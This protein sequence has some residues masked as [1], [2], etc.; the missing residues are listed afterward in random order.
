MPVFPP[1]F[2]RTLRP[3]RSKWFPLPIAIVFSSPILAFGGGMDL[4]RIGAILLATF[5]AVYFVWKRR[6]QLPSGDIEYYADRLVLTVQ[7]KRLEILF[8]E[9]EE[10]KYSFMQWQD[11]VVEVNMRSGNSHA[12]PASIARLDYFFDRLAEA[13][14]DLAKNPNF[15]RFRDT[16]VVVSQLWESRGESRKSLL[17]DKA[18][19]FFDIGLFAFASTAV[20]ILLSGYHRVHLSLLNGLA[21]FLANTVA[22][23]LVVHFARSTLLQWGNYLNLKRI[24]KR[25]KN[26]P[27]DLKRDL[28]AENRLWERLFLP[29]TALIVLIT[30]V[31]GGF[32][33]HTFDPHKPSSGLESLE[34]ASVS[35]EVQIESASANASRPSGHVPKGIASPEGAAAA[36]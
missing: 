13:R 11:G 22:A 30:L 33:Y 32:E 2:E 29:H 20:L 4:W 25:L 27:K 5:A 21:A 3:I 31:V 7:G 6:K 10:L 12:L 9:I 1:E 8:Q 23:F 35:P 24:Q 16:S 19:Y 34:S 15:A 17:H 14:P 36:Q 18:A 28:K 26:S